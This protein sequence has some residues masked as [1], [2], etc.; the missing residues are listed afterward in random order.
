MTINLRDN[1][2]R[3]GIQAI[4]HAAHVWD[5][6]ITMPK[7]Y[8]DWIDKQ[9][10]FQ[11]IH[12]A[13]TEEAL[14]AVLLNSPAD[15][16]DQI[17]EEKAGEEQIKGY[18]RDNYN[19][20][21]AAITSRIEQIVK[22]GSTYDH[23]IKQLPVDEVEAEF[24]EAVTILGDAV[25]DAEASIDRDA[26]AAARFR[27]AGRKL[28]T[29]PALVPAGYSYRSFVV[30]TEF[31]ELKELTYKKNGRF[32]ELHYTDEDLARHHDVFAA[33]RDANDLGVYLTE[34]A[35][36]KRSGMSLKVARTFAEVQERHDAAKD[37]AHTRQ[38]GEAK[39]SGPRV[40]Y[41]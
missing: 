21:R 22:S 14:G 33:R 12:A 31:G 6:K 13:A 41:L 3:T 24:I 1:V 32:P 2:V 16:W 34:L 36:G 25:G 40:A 27:V 17:I 10:K 8:D 19:N 28:M 9:R 18:I 11:E 5:M 4:N 26:E 7:E 23:I 37:A 35:G 30:F 15:E 39:P 20:I 29:L 38:V